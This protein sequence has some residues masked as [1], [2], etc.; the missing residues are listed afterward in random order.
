MISSLQLHMMWKTSLLSLIALNVH[1]ISTS[2]VSPTELPSIGQSKCHTTLAANRAACADTILN[3]LPNNF[4][5]GQFHL[6][7]PPDIYQLPRTAIGGITVQEQCRVTVDIHGE[8]PV[9][10]SWHYVWT[11]ASMLMDAC[12]DPS[13]GTTGGVYITGE[14]SGLNISIAAA[15][16]GL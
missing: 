16:A 10:A 1:H 8:A 2:T 15:S 7:D 9:Q 4:S 5:V 12:E 14:K 11:M 13:S 3:G 6:G